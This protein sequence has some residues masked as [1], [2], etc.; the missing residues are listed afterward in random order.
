MGLTDDLPTP[1][2]AS[3]FCPDWARRILVTYKSRRDPDWLLANVLKV[4]SVDAEENPNPGNS[5]I[6]FITLFYG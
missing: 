2:T 4:I 1:K 6:T 3:E 5:Q